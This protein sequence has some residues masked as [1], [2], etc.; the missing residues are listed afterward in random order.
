M[1]HM[2]DQTQTGLLDSVIDRY[3]RLVSLIHHIKRLD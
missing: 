3:D 1:T 2:K